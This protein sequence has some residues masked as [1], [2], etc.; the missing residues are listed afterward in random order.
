MNMGKL[1]N[2]SFLY[3]IKQFNQQLSKTTLPLYEE[4]LY[5]Q[6]NQTTYSGMR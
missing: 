5:L 6:P 1:N 2:F 4:E 3:L